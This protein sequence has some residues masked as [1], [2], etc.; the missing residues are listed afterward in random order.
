[1]HHKLHDARWSGV[2]VMV[3]ETVENDDPQN[4]RFLMPPSTAATLNMAAVAAQCARI[5][6]DIDPAFAEK[7]LTVAEKAWTAANE[8][9]DVFTGRTPGQGG[10]DYSDPNVTDEFYW[11]AAELFVT[12]GKAEYRDFVTSSPFF[13][14]FPGSNGG[15]AG[16]MNWGGVA[17]L[18]TISLA[19]IPNDLPQTAIDMLREQII[20]IAEERYLATIND[21]G[22]RVS[23]TGDN[24]F[25]GSSS[26]VANNGILLSLAYDFTGDKRFVDGTSEALDYLLG[27]NALAFS[28]ISG[29]GENSMQHPHHRFW[30]N[31]P[32]GGFPPPPPG[33]LSGGPN[34]NPSDDTANNADLGDV[35]PAKRY[36]D[37]IGS[38]STN[39]VAINWNAPLAW[40]AAYLD[41]YYAGQ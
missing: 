19:M 30:G 40:V 29:Y 21:E 18:G 28:F 27:R 38:Y 24:Y 39:E 8:H 3:P 16:S 2:P 10:G 36:V 34:G 12:T 32:S 25:W 22:Y 15:G 37:L 9:P 4:G 31:Q 17:A 23:F 35:G 13:T 6:K 20:D 11:A 41:A 33:A 7:C 26:D 14:A 1:V 5:W